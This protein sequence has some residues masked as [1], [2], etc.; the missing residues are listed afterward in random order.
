MCFFAMDVKRGR[1]K[2]IGVLEGKRQD[3]RDGESS[4]YVLKHGQPG[5]GSRNLAKDFTVNWVFS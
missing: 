2:C 5:S 3:K 1:E 4:G